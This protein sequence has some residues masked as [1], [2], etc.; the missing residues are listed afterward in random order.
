MTF[1]EWYEKERARFYLGDLMDDY[2]NLPSEY[3]IKKLMKNAWDARYD[4]L[5]Y[6]DI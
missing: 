3:K 4:T 2:E 5:T 1:E 6:Y